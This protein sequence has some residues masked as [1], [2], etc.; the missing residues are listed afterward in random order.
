MAEL[1][2]LPPETIRL[3]EAMSRPVTG[4]GEPVVIPSLF[5][6]FARDQRVLAALWA[7]LRPA[8]EDAAFAE[9]VEAVR[10]G[11]AAVARRLPFR[12]RR[13]EGASERE[14]V[15]GFLVTIPSMIVV[16]GLIRSSLS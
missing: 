10:A 3:L 7:S 4:G 6:Y 15:E 2:T 5:R 8:L 14:L 11:A 12:V 9:S 16:T 13:L 1:A